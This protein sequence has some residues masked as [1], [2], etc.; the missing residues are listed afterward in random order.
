MWEGAGTRAKREGGS[1]TNTSSRSVLPAGD[2][3]RVSSPLELTIHSRDC[4]DRIIRGEH[5]PDAVLLLGAGASVK[6]GVPLAGQ[7]VSMAAKWSYCA[8]HG[9]SYDDPSLTMSDWKPWLDRQPWFDAQRPFED[10]YPIAIQ[11]LLYPRESRRAFFLK[12]LASGRRPSPGY[13]ALARLISARCIRT[14][15]T[16]NFDDLV[17]RACNADRAVLHVAEIRSSEDLR[18][19]STDPLHP[20]VVY[21]HGKVASYQ[22]RNLEE[23]TKTLDP[24][25]RDEVL[26]LLRDHPLVV[27]GYRGAEASIMVDLLQR[28]AQRYGFRHG[29][30]WCVLPGQAGSLTPRVS[31][32]AAH[33]GSNF[34]LVEIAGFDEA[35]ASW[36]EGAAPARLPEFSVETD[37]PDIP[38]LRPA[39]PLASASLNTRLAEERLAEYA[40]SLGVTPSVV[41][42][43]PPWEAWLL[44]RR[45][46]RHTA[47][48]TQLT[49]A[50][51]LLFSKEE[52]TFVELRGPDTYVPIGGNV[53]DVMARTLEAIED[54]NQP[55][56]L[57]APMSQDVRRF[58]PRAVKELVVNALAHRDHDVAEP[59][60]IRIS[61][62]E[63]VVVSPGGLVGGLS[64]EDLGQPH[65]RAYRNH[66]IADVLYGTGAMDK[67]GSGLPDVRR[68]TK[69]AGGEATF[70]LTKAG[71]SFVASLRARDLD[72]D[73]ET[74]T[75][76]ADVEH[77]TSNILAVEL[78][79][80]VQVAASPHSFR[81]HI[82]ERHSGQSLPG[83]AMQPGRLLTFSDLADGPLHGDVVGRAERRAPAEFLE[84]PDEERLLVQLL[85]STM[86]TWAFRRGLRS[87]ARS[88][89][90]WFPRQ[91][92]GA[93]EIT[94]RARV[95]EATRTVTKPKLSGTTGNVR[96]WEHE[97]VRFRF[98]RYGDDW[99]LQLSPC[100]VFTRDG[101]SDVLTGPKVG[102]LA[103]RRSAREFNPQVENDLHFWLWIVTA[104]SP[105]APLDDEAVFVRHGFVSCDVV[106]APTAIG[107]GEPGEGSEGADDLIDEVA[108]IVSE[109]SS[110]DA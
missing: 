99:A 45:I 56:R 52:V 37:E 47:E 81:R 10:Q 30:Y 102:P 36:A 60:R 89:R 1:N 32:L 15:L 35:M 3:E 40:T 4:L 18:E 39:G 25:I 50:G 19:F 97:A 75:A 104:G 109:Q 23:E 62:R 101:W 13:E 8:E 77:F 16:V 100:F 31:Q 107:G 38:D 103:T 80:R 65:A 70:G 2:H 64:L 54:F 71:S 12:A 106:D 91:E 33:L 44:E 86:L 83:F 34:R 110:D 87:D 105:E 22:D 84:N 28:E 41:R 85:N 21:L 11:R 55:Y 9:R 27:V 66:V 90:L 6:S 108:L 7:M 59:V 73:P 82:Y 88:Q 93:T 20:Q 72:P 98:R 17:I 74:G 68:W 96:Y 94:Y 46:A 29:L 58:D 48:G 67:K 78:R 76:S 43:G 5:P 49:R 57:K 61:A 53:F 42:D 92:D 24:P 69:Q 63:F 79:S 14:V 95:R 51:R 26:P